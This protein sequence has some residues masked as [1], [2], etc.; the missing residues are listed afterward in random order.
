MTDRRS[1]HRKN[2]NQFAPVQKHE[3]RS[4]PD[5]FQVDMLKSLPLWIYIRLKLLCIIASRGV[6]V[7]TPRL[8]SATVHRSVPVVPERPPCLDQVS[9]YRRVCKIFTF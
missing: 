2:G 8:S 9:G 3:T 5:T 4:S 1:L 6:A 7:H